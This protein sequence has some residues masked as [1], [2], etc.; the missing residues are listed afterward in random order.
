[1]SFLFRSTRSITLSDTGVPLRSRFGGRVSASR[2][3]KVS[4]V[5]AA[6]R[7]RSNLISSFPVDVFKAARQGDVPRS[8]PTPSVLVSPSEWAPGQPMTVAD[9]LYASQMDL[10]RHGN[11]IGIIAARD[12]NGLPRVIDLVPAETV[13][14]KHRGGRIDEYLIDFRVYRPDQIWH[15]RQYIV[16]GIPMGLSPIAHAAFSLEAHTSAEEFALDWFH[17][18]ATPSALLRN[19]AKT[20]KPDESE[21]IKHRFLANTRNG[22]PVVVGKDWT[23]T[24]ISATAKTS[25]FLER[26]GASTVEIARFFDVPADMIDAGIP[27]SSI[28]YANMT[29]RNTQ[30]LI[31]SIGPAVKRREDALSRLTLSDRY[32]KLN[33][34]ALL[35]MDPQTRSD[36]LLAKKAARV[37]TT[38]EVR[39][40]DNMPPLTPAQLDEI[41]ADAALVMSQPATTPKE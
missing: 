40:L 35:R 20:L 1:M 14:V 6:C 7:L 39:A 33:T 3:M 28:T 37:Y 27:G 9:W 34:D 15:E 5:W 4:A 13:I 11:A 10:D 16:A 8:M 19:E 29:Q 22:D 25:Q 21:K 30:L 2:A 41:A 17:S 38:S 18:G 31:T 12:G 36:V 24:A 23:Y 26:I 32:V